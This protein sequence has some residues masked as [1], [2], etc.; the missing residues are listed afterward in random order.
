M[1]DGTLKFAQDDKGAEVARKFMSASANAQRLAQEIIALRK[2]S[3]SWE[4]LTGTGKGAQLEAKVNQLRLVEK[5]RNDLGA[6]TGSDVGLMS[7]PDAGDVFESGAEEML[8]TLGREVGVQAQDYAAQ[9]LSDDL[10]GT[11]MP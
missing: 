8:Q 9:Y 10:G 7:V 2:E 5:E 4:R 6:L 1:P 11:I 3:G